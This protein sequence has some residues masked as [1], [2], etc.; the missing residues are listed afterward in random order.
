M[1]TLDSENLI[2][3]DSVYSVS[4]LNQKIKQY[5]EYEIGEIEVRGEISNFSSPA[6]GHIYFTLKDERSQIRCALFRNYAQNMRFNLQDGLQVLTTAIPS[7]YSA[8]GDFQLIVKMIKPD[9]E[10]ALKAKFDEIKIKLQKEGIFDSDKKRTLPKWP[11][12]IGIITSPSGAVIRDILSV[13]KRRCPMI[14]VIIY[15]CLVQGPQACGDLKKSIT[16]ANERNECDVLIIARG[17]GSLE[18]LWAFNEEELAYSIF[19]SSL[20]IV[21]AVGHETDVTIADFASDLRAPTPS[22]AAELLSPDTTLIEEKIG[23]IY[24]RILVSAGLRIQFFQ[25]RLESLKKQLKDPTLEL[26]NSFQL[27]DDLHIRLTRTIGVLLT[28]KKTKLASLNIQI[29]NNNLKLNISNLSLHLDIQAKSLDGYA[30]TVIEKNI[31]CYQKVNAALHNLSPVKTLNRG[32]AIV[33]TKDGKIIKNSSEVSV[34]S[35]IFATVANGKFSAKV[36]DVG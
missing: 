4:K 24:K 22:A 9:G 18:D 2:P 11:K 19:H 10:G 32:Y 36:E 33:Q 27:A 26:Q 29:K 16:I 13:L 8:R 31:S 20:P 3:L 7:I 12:K 5:L 34:K 15:P 30:T 28:N 21:S 1:N 6:S 14:P 35:K 25:Q 17:G 23:S